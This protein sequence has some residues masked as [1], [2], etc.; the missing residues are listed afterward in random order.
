MTNPLIFA[1]FFKPFAKISGL[2]NPCT[3]NRDFICKVRKRRPI[4]GIN[5]MTATPLQHSRLQASVASTITGKRVPGLTLA[6]WLVI[7]ATLLSAG[8]HLINLSAIGDANTYYTAAV[9]SML[10]SWHNFFFAAAEPGGSVTVDKP[11]LGLW[12]EAA[13]AFVLGVN[14]I[15]VS[16]PNILS[17][18][19][20]VPLLYHLVRK[21]FGV[22]AGVAAAATLA[23]TPVVV[24]AD[25]NNTMDGLLT[26]VLLL[27][28]WACLRAT[29]TG[30]LRFLLLGAFIVGLGFNIKMLQA[31]LPL[32]A[33][34]ALYL[35]DAR[36]GWLRKILSLGLATLLLAAISLTWALIVDSVPVDQR[37]YIGSSTDNTVMEL[38]VG[39][40]GLNRLFGGHR[41]NAPAPG[42]AGAND[43][44]PIPPG[45]APQTGVDAPQPPAKMRPQGFQSPMNPPRPPD[46]GPGQPGSNPPAGAGARNETG[47]PGWLRFFQAPLGK[48]MSWLL[49]F[50]LIGLLP[51]AVMARPR[52]PLV[53]GLHKGLI[54][55][56]GWLGACLAFFSLAEF[57]HAYYM[58]MLAPAL[59]A[60]VGGGLA[61]LWQ[62]QARWRWSVALLVLAAA[63]TIAFQ[64][65]LAA[66][67]GEGQA[68][69]IALGPGLLIS[70]LGML[71]IV[72]LTRVTDNLSGLA[73]ATLLA[74]MLAIPL[75]WTV[76]TVIDPGLNINLPA[77]YDGAQAGPGNPG[78]P[79]RSPQEQQNQAL[80]AYLEP[81][82]QDTE[83]LLAVSNAFTGAP[84]ILATGRPVLYMGGF[85]GGDPVVSA[86]DLAEMVERGELR[87]VLST[88]QGRVEITHWLQTACSAAPE[89]SQ[90]GPGRGPQSS[91]GGPENGATL[92]LCR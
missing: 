32:P 54:L 60:M 5:P 11:P 2:Q 8:L 3:K 17:G 55:W 18:V 41:A 13:F 29:E 84:F 53:S 26:F 20:S 16:L 42:V 9:K 67:F 23:V 90:P 27:A 81:R 49:P 88:G 4:F 72:V 61:A 21:H 12:I 38:I 10:Q 36:V 43:D 34:Y 57:F 1:N 86:A 56:G 47:N 7:G 44:R 33:F 75:C 89:F 77:A 70:S 76:L 71:G 30:R 58:V 80:L 25:R 52:L 64:I 78:A 50:T 37:P 40:N 6:A 45:L 74:A 69:W 35:L 59:A 63:I 66:Q 73:Y 91:P 31:F 65:Y 39:H 79:G 15:A 92:Y 62:M 14:G 82:T 46:T 68:W 85:S 24:A 51:L 22:W 83:Y 87:Y 19:V 48:E 28:A